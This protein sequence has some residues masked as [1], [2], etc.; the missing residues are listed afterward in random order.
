[1]TAVMR[2]HLLSHPP[3]NMPVMK[4]TLFWF[5]FLPD[6]RRPGKLYRTRWRMS[7]TQANGYPGAVKDESYGSLMRNLPESP[8]EYDL[9]GIGPRKAAPSD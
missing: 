3:A 8:N 1:M 5:W 9:T 4:H 6:E 7:E 2:A